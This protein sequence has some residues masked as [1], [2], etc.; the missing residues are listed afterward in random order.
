M[1]FSR[2]IFKKEINGKTVF[3]NSLKLF[4][5]CHTPFI[6]DFSLFEPPLSD[7]CEKKPFYAQTT[8]KKLGGGSAKFS[9][10]LI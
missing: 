7:V 8:I 5:E 2:W 4:S 1:A 10:I 3:S 9:R 6:N